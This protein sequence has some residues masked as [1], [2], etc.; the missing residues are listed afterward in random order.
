MIEDYLFAKQ[1]L[2][3]RRE[4][5][6]RYVG[7]ILEQCGVTRKHLPRFS[8]FLKTGVERYGWSGLI[9]LSYLSFRQL[10]PEEGMSNYLRKFLAD[11]AGWKFVKDVARSIVQSRQHPSPLEFLASLKGFR[12]SFWRELW[13]LQQA[14][15]RKIKP[16]SRINITLPKLV[17]QQDLD[18]LAILFDDLNVRLGN[19]KIDD[20]KISHSTFELVSKDDFKE[21][22]SIK[23][24]EQVSGWRETELKGWSPQ[25][26]PYALF[27]EESGELLHPQQYLS[28]GNYYLVISAAYLAGLPEQNR[29]YVENCIAE[30]G[31]LSL[32]FGMFRGTLIAVESTTDL[33]FLGV[34]VDKKDQR[35]LIWDDSAK[36]LAGA[37]DL[38]DVFVG[39][40]PDLII[41]QPKLFHEK[42]LLLMSDFDGQAKPID[43]SIECNKIKLN[44]PVPSKGEI[45]I[46][47]IGRYREISEQNLNRRL[48]F[49]CLP[50]CNIE[51]PDGL[52]G[53]TEEPV[54]EIK[55]DKNISVAF[56]NGC[57]A[58]DGDKRRW[59]IPPRQT[60]AEGILTVEGNISIRLAKMI[61]RASLQDENMFPLHTLTL[62]DFFDL[63]NIVL[64]GYPDEQAKLFM[65]KSAKD[66][67]LAEL[68]RFDKAGRIKF[69]TSALKDTLGLGQ[70]AAG[71]LYVEHYGQKI[72]TETRILNTQEI[73]NRLIANDDFS[74]SDALILEQKKALEELRKGITQ[75]LYRS[76]LSVCDC[77]PKRL[78]GWGKEILYCAWFFD[79][80]Q[81]E[82]LQKDP[83]PQDESRIQAF[84][85]LKKARSASNADKE[86][87]NVSIDKLIDDLKDI[88][89]RPSITRWQN[90]FEK[91]CASLKQDSELTELLIEWKNEVFDENFFVEYNCRIGQMAAGKELTNAWKYYINNDFNRA[92]NKAKIAIANASSPVKDL[93]L[94]LINILLYRNNTPEQ[95]KALTGRHHRKLFPYIERSIF[96]CKN[97]CGETFEIKT[98]LSDGVG[99]SLLPLK[100]D[101]VQLF[102]DTNF[103]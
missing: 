102:E 57:V 100:K 1:F 64:T 98:V 87:M 22:Y 26:R 62:D 30:F 90:E 37:K 61:H 76:C 97:A 92:Y 5:S 58:V 94:I 85:W 84:N 49:C 18:R 15:I 63:E 72:P 29:Q 9:S 38:F 25:K 10:L 51:W 80:T 12:P 89:W 91:I 101:D 82:D 21:V 53:L 75:K 27:D 79:G 3:K 88:S 54:V 78:S 59:A 65:R 50:D 67:A 103:L 69:K 46:E 33:S 2:F 44:S 55:G 11:P 41:T 77:L 70:F 74:W 39:Q 95:V 86:S 83:F 14:D 43:I 48:S 40:L 6:F 19:Y 35:H 68:G 34:D 60:F 32:P 28:E 4:Y 23:V 56:K 99:I 47:P 66:K 16:S 93:A 81:L 24:K 45:W 36:R 13:V 8:E 7:P 96:F 42:K 52:Y 73:I 20:K 71:Q 17:Y 31:L